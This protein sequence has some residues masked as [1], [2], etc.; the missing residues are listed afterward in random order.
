MEDKPEIGQ[1]DVEIEISPEMSCE[2]FARVVGQFE[3]L[4]AILGR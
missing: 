3:F 1:A 2:A 4:R